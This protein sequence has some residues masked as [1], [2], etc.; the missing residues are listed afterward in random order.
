V[1]EAAV[2]EDEWVR[3][4]IVDLQGSAPAI[5]VQSWRLDGS[6]VFDTRD[7]RTFVVD[8]ERYLTSL[9]HLRLARFDAQGQLRIDDH[10]WIVPSRPDETY[11]IEDARITEIDGTYWITFTAV[12]MDSFGVNLVSTRDFD[13]V[14]AHGMIFCPENKDVC[15]FP[16]KIN[17]RYY[18]IHRP[19]VSFVG[20]PSMWVS[21]SHDLR[22][23]GAHRCILRP[24]DNACKRIGVGPE[25]IWTERGWLV[26]YHACDFN[27]HYALHLC[28]LDHEDPTRVIANSPAILRPQEAYERSGF[29][30]QVVY[31]NGWV[32]KPNG[33]IEIYYGAADTVVAMASASEQELLD[34]LV[35]LGP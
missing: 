9:S 10:P 27:D 6:H 5:K 23:F 11:G 13:R 17:G 19:L 25:P 29:M 28:L 34:S 21:E 12:S 31:S 22:H 3:V 4:P 2:A 32:R 33:I 18:A 35:V 7:P 15:F 1:A 20:K 8:G 26:L 16:K 30:Q 24:D 14:D